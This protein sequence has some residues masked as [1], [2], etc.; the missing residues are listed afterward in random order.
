MKKPNKSHLKVVG[1]LTFLVVLC[2]LTISAARFQASGVIKEVRAEVVLLDKGNN[3]IQPES[4]E[5]LVL[6]KYGQLKGRPIHEVDMRGIEEFLLNH[7]VETI[8]ARAVGP[9]DRIFGW[10]RTCSTWNNLVSSTWN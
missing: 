7:Q 6:K 9:V 1:W 2:G 10:I 3:L 5:K 4:F 8:V